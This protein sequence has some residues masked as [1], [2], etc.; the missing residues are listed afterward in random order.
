LFVALVLVWLGLVVR[1]ILAALRRRDE[2]RPILILFAISSL[3]IA[4][5][6]GAA[7]AYGEHKTPPQPDAA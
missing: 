4:G 6:Y 1:R 2:Q 5:F 3:A 7:L